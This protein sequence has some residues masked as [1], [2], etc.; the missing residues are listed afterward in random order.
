MNRF[1]QPICQ[2]LVEI[3]IVAVLLYAY[4]YHYGATL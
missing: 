4:T 2:A 1:V 3:V